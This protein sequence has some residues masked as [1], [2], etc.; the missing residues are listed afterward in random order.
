MLFYNIET[1]EYPRY[2]GDLELLGWE[3]GNPLPENWVEVENNDPVYDSTTQKFI[4]LLPE[5]IDG[6]YKRKY[7]VQD[8]SAEELE[9]MKPLPAEEELPY[10]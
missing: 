8:L 10:A 6:K 3:V 5:V 9:Q 1:Q 4:E 7:Q 2:Q